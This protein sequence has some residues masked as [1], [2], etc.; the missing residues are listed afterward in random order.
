M[1]TL[2]PWQEDAWRRL[3][4]NHALAHALLISGPYG[5]GKTAFAHHLG[6]RLVCEQDRACGVCRACTFARK[7]DHPDILIIRA[8]EG[9]AEITVDH[10]RALNTFLALTPHLGKRRVSIIEAADQLNRSAANALLKTLEEPPAESFV[11]LVSHS[12]ARLLPT[13][14]SRC[15]KIHL[16]KP[17]S[18]AALS[19]LQD[20]GVQAAAAA[21]KISHGAPLRAEALPKDALDTAFRLLETLENLAAGVLDAATAGEGWQALDLTYG[22][23]L[24]T[25]ILADLAQLA[26]LDTLSNPF[27]GDWQ[28]RLRRLISQLDLQRLFTL[29]DEVL[30]VY[31]LADAPLDRRL[32]WDKLFLGFE[33]LRAH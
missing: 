13:I 7:G 1:L 8:D 22:L 5:I 20:K 17:S 9:K 3:P 2:F 11:V 32:I 10:A 30:E 23:S 18:D 14:R 28:T 33:Q 19:Y 25:D 16:G 31:A 4:Q 26:A 6:M 29:W 27:P 24:F 21:L 15:Q 12:T